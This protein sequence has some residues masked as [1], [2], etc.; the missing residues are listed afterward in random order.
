[1]GIAY[2]RI[3]GGVVVQWTANGHLPMLDRVK[4]FMLQMKPKCLQGMNVADYI[5]EQY[6]GKT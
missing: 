6:A 1:L 3:N 4:R 5:S 2:A